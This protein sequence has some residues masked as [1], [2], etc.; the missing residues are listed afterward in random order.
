MKGPQSKDS[1]F[2]SLGL[3][4]YEEEKKITML[5]SLRLYENL[6]II[7]LFSFKKG[8]E[9]SL[10]HIIK[11]TS[12]YKFSFKVSKLGRKKMDQKKKIVHGFLLLQHY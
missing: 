2:D 11:L 9:I 6:L 5:K 10:N 4:P 7:I 3:R 12:S 1:D 8:Q